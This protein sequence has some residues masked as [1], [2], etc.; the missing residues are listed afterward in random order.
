MSDASIP[1]FIW[2]VVGARATEAV[3]GVLDCDVFE[4]LARA[5]AKARELKEYAHPS[6]HPADQEFTEFLGDHTLVAKMHP[7]VEIG[8]RGYGKTRLRFT[9]ELSAK[10]HTAELR[11][12]GGR[13]VAIGA[14]EGLVAVQL[15]Y[16][17]VKLH[18]ELESVAAKLSQPF[19]L[20]PG[21]AIG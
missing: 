19:V 14:G 13:I 18:D 12:L 11:I 15:K 8:L 9:L 4:Q 20:S 3:R 6:K 5:W 1:G 2:S 10:I 17:N 21:L 7:V 16:R